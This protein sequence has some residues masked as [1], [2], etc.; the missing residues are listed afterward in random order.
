MSASV[1]KRTFN[2]AGGM[3]ALCQ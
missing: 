1:Q 2:G 3:S